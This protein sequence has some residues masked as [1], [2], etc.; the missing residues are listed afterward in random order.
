MCCGEHKNAEGGGGTRYFA[1]EAVINL[2]VLNFR[3]L[4]FSIQLVVGMINVI[5]NQRMKTLVFD[6]RDFITTAKNF[7]R[8]ALLE[9][10]EFFTEHI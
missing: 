5:I 1:D 9:A 6:F 7:P 10:K 8:G 4:G 3:F 2:K